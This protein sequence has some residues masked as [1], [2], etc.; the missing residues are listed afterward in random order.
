MLNGIDLVHNTIIAS[1]LLG[2]IITFI[3]ISRYAF[4]QEDPVSI[5]VLV[6]YEYRG[7]IDRQGTQSFT[8]SSFYLNIIA[9]SK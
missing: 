7:H 4:F 5:F 2:S 6:V 1:T 3:P 9:L 8:S